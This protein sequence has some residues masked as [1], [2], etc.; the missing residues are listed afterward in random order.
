MNCL[1][2]QT[3]FNR[4]TGQ[5]VSVPCGHCLACFQMRG[6]TWT[7]RIACEMV[8]H[9]H[10][11]CGTF[12][13][14][15][16]HLPVIHDED[17]LY[18][19]CAQFKR[20]D[21]SVLLSLFRSPE[22]QGLINVY[23]G[24]P[25]HDTRH[26]QLFIKRLRKAISYYDSKCSNAGSPSLRYYI[27]GEYGPTTQRPHYHF[28]LFSESEWFGNHYKEVISKA[29]CT[30]SKSGSSKSLGK[31]TCRYWDRNTDAATY[32][33]QYLSCS[34]SL[35]PILKTF[36]F[37][38]RAV[39]S[40]KPPLGFCAFTSSQIRNVL[41]AS[42]TSISLHD[43]TD[44]AVRSIS[45]WRSL[46]TWLFEK[47]PRYFTLS[48]CDRLTLYKL[49]CYFEEFSEFHSWFLSEW[50][51]IVES[52]KPG[53]LAFPLRVALQ[54]DDSLSEARYWLNEEYR[55]KVENRL[56]SLWRCSSRFVYFCERF[57]LSFVLHYNQIKQYWLKKDY[58]NLKNQLLKQQELGLKY[59]TRKDW[60]PEYFIS[61]IDPLFYENSRG[62]PEYEYQVIADSFGV[63]F[64]TA[65][66]GS[67]IPRFRD[68]KDSPSFQRTLLRVESFAKNGK[69]KKMRNEYLDNNPQFKQLHNPF[70]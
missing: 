19:Y 45:L 59:R 62:I 25:H 35:P 68:Y 40:R 60:Y 66:D 24:I 5:Y 48:D 57:E 28:I 46:Q 38:Q 37:N 33:A 54:L 20:A 70:Y 11:V 30:E 64:D 69:D 50:Q 44:N 27:C 34:V 29:W 26:L 32:V 49:S 39:F 53:T 13:Y 17:E 9:K 8:A 18:S 56:L 51:A 4:Y 22:S 52:D 1:N 23:R 15:T 47:C 6:D 55:E 10:V 7:T 61:E 31:V 43:P 3:I 67:Y 2:P 63:G 16:K 41:D 65:P 42:L 12:T 36:P 14:K 21:Y 58:E